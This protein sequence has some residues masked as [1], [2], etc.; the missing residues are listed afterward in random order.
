MT[1]ILL[2]DGNNIGYA[3]ILQRL[4]KIVTSQQALF[5]V[6]TDWVPPFGKEPEH[7]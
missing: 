1:R 6:R 5:S 7:G 2:I 4:L 3:S